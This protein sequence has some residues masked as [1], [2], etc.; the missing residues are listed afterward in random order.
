MGI[1]TAE[2][3]NRT[4]RTGDDYVI[5]HQNPIG[6]NNFAV[7]IDALA[8]LDCVCRNRVAV[9]IQCYVSTKFLLRFF[10]RLAN[11]RQRHHKIHG[12]TTLILHGAVS[13]SGGRIVFIRR[14]HDT[15]RQV[16]VR[17]A[18]TD[19]AVQVELHRAVVGDGGAVFVLPPF[20][21]VDFGEVGGVRA[22]NRRAFHQQVARKV[23]R[24]DRCA[25]RNDKVV[26]RGVEN[27]VFGCQRFHQLVG[28]AF[29]KVGQRGHTVAVGGND[30][31]RL[32][33]RTVVFVQREL[34]VRQRQT[35][36][37][38]VD[39]V[40][41][42]A[43]NAGG[44]TGFEVHHD[45]V[46]GT[47]GAVGDTLQL[48]GVGNRLFGQSVGFCV[49]FIGI[50]HNKGAR[51]RNTH[52]DRIGNDVV[53]PFASIRVR[54][55]ARVKLFALV[56]RLRAVAVIH[57]HGRRVERGGNVAFV[58]AIHR[59]RIR[60][61]QR[62]RAGQK[63][64][65]A[66]VDLEVVRDKTRLL[67][68]RG[69]HRR[70]G[71]N[72]VIFV[73]GDHLR[74][75]VAA[76]RL[77]HGR[78]A[79]RHFDRS[80]VC[81][82]RRS[83]V[84]SLVGRHLVQRRRHGEVQHV[85]PVVGDGVVGRHA[86]RQ[87]NGD[88]LTVHRD[89][90]R[91]VIADGD[92]AGGL[93]R[94]VGPHH[95]IGGIV[96]FVDRQH[97]IVKGH[98]FGENILHRQRAY[99]SAR[100]RDRQLPVEHSVDFVVVV[101][102]LRVGGRHAGAR[103]R[104]RV[105]FND[106]GA[107]H[108]FRL[109]FHRIHVVAGGVLH[110]FAAVLEAMD[111]VQIPD[112]TGREIGEIQFLS[113]VEVFIR[114]KRK[115]IEAV[116]R[117][118][119]IG[120]AFD[121]EGVIV[122]RSVHRAAGE[123]E[124][125]HLRHNGIFQRGRLRLREILATLERIVV[126]PLVA[127]GT[128]EFREGRRDVHVP[129]D[130]GQRI[131]CIGGV[132]RHVHVGLFQR[133]V[134]VRTERFRH[135]D[136]MLAGVIARFEHRDVFHARLTDFRLIRSRVGEDVIGLGRIAAEVAIREGDLGRRAAADREH[137]RT[138]EIVSFEDIRQH[139]A[140]QTGTGMAVDR[141]GPRDR[142]HA[143]LVKADVGVFGHGVRVAE[144]EVVFIP[145]F[146]FF[147]V[148]LGRYLD[149]VVGVI[150][151]AVRID[152]PGA[153]GNGIRLVFHHI[154]GE[155]IVEIGIADD[156][157]LLVVNR[158][159]TGNGAAETDDVVVAVQR[160]FADLEIA[161]VHHAARH[162]VIDQRRGLGIFICAENS[163]EIYDTVGGIHHRVRFLNEQVFVLRRRR[164]GRLGFA[165]RVAA[166]ATAAAFFKNDRPLA[167]G[168]RLSV[169]VAD[170]VAGF[171]VETDRTADFIARVLLHQRVADRDRRVEVDGRKT[172]LRNGKLADDGPCAENRDVVRR[173][174]TEH[175]RQLIRNGMTRRSERAESQLILHLE[176]KHIVFVDIQRLG[177]GRDFHP[178]VVGLPLQ[179]HGDNIAL[180]QF[181]LGGRRG[182]CRQN[183]G[184]DGTEHDRDRKHGQRRAFRA[185]VVLFGQM[186][187][188][189][190]KELFEFAH[191]V[192]P[193]F[194]INRSVF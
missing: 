24:R 55:A 178:T 180:L 185:A 97:E 3:R 94:F 113:D 71:E 18:G 141:N 186:L 144:I 39:L 25:A 67:I 82:V 33:R 8:N 44:N 21:D 41:D 134:F 68:V 145:R 43:F 129:L 31:V 12:L 85:A 96:L 116:R 173:H 103:R 158:R 163:G 48:H 72:A 107:I 155:L 183:E 9:R 79:G 105:G 110:Q 184:V 37:L 91:A 20:L 189:F 27:V 84:R 148:D 160:G 66:R 149:L 7:L 126:Q 77:H 14:L 5:G 98:A 157:R 109:A 135:F 45:G 159:R 58:L 146:G 76:E 136:G 181:V 6:V 50:F 191:V 104:D 164:L 152:H 28:R 161:D 130:G 150:A 187:D 165:G 57:A 29:G 167:E 80:G 115:A 23:A 38:A 81:K 36:V 87:H 174:L 188:Q 99:D 83:A 22:V 168:D 65:A 90:R 1:Q 69:L 147:A 140:I 10:V 34:R 102:G 118:G 190:F 151:A 70:F 92:G 16:D 124:L 192:S 194:V 127:A 179:G 128:E 51:V 52:R 95:R 131:G 133:V 42:N 132:H 177:G 62:I 86:R 17:V 35:V 125:R 78:V 11:L 2:R 112:R 46:V 175:R 138:G 121:F 182:N 4:D 170:D 59:Q 171:T 53:F 166:A 30:V 123:A 100:D 54:I 162:M 93:R 61:N 169:A 19:F 26:R 89:G 40:H 137:R 75:G 32:I 106:R 114:V 63:I 117:N 120:A 47:D 15:R 172:V 56:A 176:A 156:Q 193:P 153:V 13:E 73:N 108:R 60:Q 139:P 143:V 122:V 142:S 119:G 154:V 101:D 88:G 49:D 64:R 111:L 74:L